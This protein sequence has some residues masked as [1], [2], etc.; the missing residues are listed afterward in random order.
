MSKK[1]RRETQHDLVQFLNPVT[2]KVVKIHASSLRAGLVQV[3]IV[4]VE[5]LVWAAPEA[6][7]N[8]SIRHASL[9]DSLRETIRRIQATF[10]EFDH[11][12]FEKWDEDFRHDM[13]PEREVEVWADAAD[14]Y[15]AF[16]EDEKVAERRKDIYELVVQCLGSSQRE[17][18]RWLRPV[19]LKRA[20]AEAI[21]EFSFGR[22]GR[23]RSGRSDLD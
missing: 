17:I 16:A 14:V 11:N 21:V 20:E 9:P 15:L 3:Q 1:S 12:S 22:P 19:A 5:G 7:K 13:H 8:P 6:I 2:N 10:A 18:L 23:G 4:G